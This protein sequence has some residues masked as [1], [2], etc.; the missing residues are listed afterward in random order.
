LDGDTDKL[1]HG[2]KT[3]FGDKFRPKT[4]ASSE[5]FREL[6]ES[7]SSMAECAEFII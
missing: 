4:L 7:N 1:D 6:N 3:I 5:P 2:K